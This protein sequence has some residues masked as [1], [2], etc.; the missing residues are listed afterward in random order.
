MSIFCGF[1]FHGDEVGAVGHAG[2]LICAKTLIIS[3]KRAM[4]QSRRERAFD[5]RSSG[6]VRLEARLQLVRG[7]HQFGVHVVTSEFKTCEGRLNRSK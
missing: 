5:A 4:A 7:E 3:A 6:E 2:L 1:P